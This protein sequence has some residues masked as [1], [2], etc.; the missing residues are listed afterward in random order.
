MIEHH[1]HFNDQPIFDFLLVEA[2]AIGWKLKW[3]KD[4]KA[5]ALGMIIKL[6][7]YTKK[8]KRNASK[9]ERAK[10]LK[11]KQEF[12]TKGWTILKKFIDGKIKK[13]EAEKQL[14]KLFRETYR[15]AFL[16]GWRSSGLSDWVELSDEDW[17]WLESALKEEFTYLSQFLDDI[18]KG[19]QK[20][21]YRRR[22]QMYVDTLEHVFWVGKISVIPEAFVIDWVVDSK[23]ERCKGCLFLKLNS[24][25]TVFTLPTVPKAGATPCLSNCRCKLRAR[26]PRSQLEY[27]AAKNKKKRS[28]LKVLQ[29]IK[30]GLR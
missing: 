1:Q 2:K 9:R 30:K 13:D 23:A 14:R 15:Q 27:T 24:P 26:P 6:G 7:D 20:M 22:W 29:D 10:F 25:Y 16:M 5:K 8:L 11:L 4:K 17:Q 3:N 28:I 18:Q 21:P 19:Y 12:E